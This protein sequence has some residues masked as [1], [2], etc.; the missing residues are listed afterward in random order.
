MKRT[1]PERLNDTSGIAL[2][3]VIF[4]LVIIAA[5]VAGGYYSAAQEFQ[6]GRGMKNFTTSFYAAETG[7]WSVIEEWDPV[8][9][10]A[11]APGDSVTVGPIAVEGGA[12]YSAVVWRAGSAADSVKRYFYIESTGRAAGLGSGERRQAVVARVRFHDLCCDAAVTALDFLDLGIGSQNKIVGLN[13]DPPGSW[14]ASACIDYPPDSIP[15]ARVVASSKIDDPGK[16]EGWAVDYTVDASMTEAALLTFDDVTYN[17]LVQ[18]ADHTFSG[19]NNFSFGSNPTTTPDG[20]CDTS[21]PQNWGAPEDPSHPCFNYF[22]I[23]HVTGNLH[24]LGNKS[25]Q[26]ILLVGDNAEADLT[27][28]GPF[29]FYGLVLVRDDLI[30]TG[31]VR[32]YGGALVVDD[33]HMNG[34]RPKLQYSTCAIDR[35]LRL[36]KLARPK[37]LTERAWVELF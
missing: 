33:V 15:G 14:P 20:K 6:I 22:P 24:L 13:D 7:V 32:L 36:S 10:N 23:I 3:V 21:N 18:M 1:V 4:A 28:T 8:L 16:V 25:A 5:I 2:A 17:D 37:L 19:D 35:A 11:L 31:P 9:Y 12:S 29:D 34:V 30:M 27:M 26:G